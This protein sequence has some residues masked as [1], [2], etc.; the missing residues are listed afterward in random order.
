MPCE[1]SAAPAL[2]YGLGSEL[3]FSPADPDAFLADPATHARHLKR[4]GHG[5]VLA[6]S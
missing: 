6:M 5:L 1:L 4:E 3:R 2:R